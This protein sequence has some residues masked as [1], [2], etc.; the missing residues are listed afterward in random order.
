MNCD[1]AIY[2][3]YQLRQ[4]AAHILRLTEFDEAVFEQKI[5]NITVLADGSLA[6]HF[7]DGRDRDMAKNVITIPAT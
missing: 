6:F 5:E 4:I 3:D 1:N 7:T 2:A